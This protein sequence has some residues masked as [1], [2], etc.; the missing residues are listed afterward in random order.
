MRAHVRATMPELP[1]ERR[2]RY[3]QDWGIR[4]EDARILVDVPGLGA[5]A[6]KAVAAL[7]GG[8]TAKDI[9]NW[10]RQEVLAYLNE[11]GGSPAELTPEML[12]EL[13]GLFAAGKISRSQAKEVLDESLREQKWPRDI[14]EEQN[15]S[16]V[17]DEQV[18]AQAIEEVLAA[19]PGFTDEYRAADDKLKKKKQGFVMGQVRDA[20]D[21]KANMQVLTR[22][23]AQ[24]LVS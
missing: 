1:A 13:V 9:V 20:L 7:D 10:T 6:E 18:L 15:L 12:A 24:R 17:S 5:Y 21:G 2:A 19:N 16:Q 3:M 23:L 4:E 22:L 14:V 11:S 8:G